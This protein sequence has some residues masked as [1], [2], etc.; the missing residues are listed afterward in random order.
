[1]ILNVL[2]LQLMNRP[3]K[4]TVPQLI[5]IDMDVHANLFVRWNHEFLM[6]IPSAQLVTDNK[7][8]PPTHVIE[9]LPSSVE[10]ILPTCF[11]VKTCFQ[12]DAALNWVNMFATL[13]WVNCNVAFEW[14]NKSSPVWV[15]I[16]VQVNLAS[17]WVN[18]FNAHVRVNSPIMCTNMLCT[19]GVRAS[20]WQTRVLTVVKCQLNE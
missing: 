15:D 4:Q 10:V 18:V 2:V 1:M 7:V 9:T 12:V 5:T 14:L 13:D 11:W 19:W 3:C 8:I 6:N 16:Y 20:A 17:E